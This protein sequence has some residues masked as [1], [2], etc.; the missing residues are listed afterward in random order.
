M[1]IQKT[2]RKNPTKM[3]AASMPSQGN[4]A[5]AGQSSET[6]LVTAHNAELLAQAEPSPVQR[7]QDRL[8]Q[9]FTAQDQ[10]GDL[11][12]KDLRPLGFAA[13]IIISL[14]A[15]TLIVQLVRWII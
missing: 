5:D 6:M 9:E 3:R 4:N 12:L 15:W 7:I 10:Q 8:E 11:P 2:R 13:A 14:I 1:L